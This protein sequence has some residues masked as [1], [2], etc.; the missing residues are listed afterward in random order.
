[1]K[2]AMAF[3][4]WLG[5]EQDQE[6]AQGYERTYEQDGRMVH[7]KWVR[8]PP[9]GEY[10]VIVGERFSVKISGEA[11]NID[12][13]RSAVSSLDLAGL[14]ALKNEGVKPD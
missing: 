14:E 13:L 11:P 9:G 8:S 10:A 1:M 7:E 2:G 6:T 12:E 3:A 5:V 4:G